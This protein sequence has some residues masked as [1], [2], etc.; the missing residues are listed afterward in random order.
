[1]KY[2]PILTGVYTLSIFALSDFTG[3]C[4]IS[5]SNKIFLDVNFIKKI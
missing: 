1:M 2:S 3:K 5:E 4:I